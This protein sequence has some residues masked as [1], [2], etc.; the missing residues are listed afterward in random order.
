MKHL[1][2]KSLIAGL[3]ILPLIAHA[4]GTQT[5]GGDQCKNEINKQRVTIE[6]WIFDGHASELDFSKTSNW[7]YFGSDGKQSYRS[8]ML[9]VL[10]EG[11]VLITCYLDPASNSKIEGVD[12]KSITVGNPA[13][14]ST[15]INYEDKHGRSRIDCNYDLVM[16][17]NSLGDPNFKNIHHE[18]AS[19]AGLE[20][21]TSDPSDMRISNQL[22][23]FES[24]KKVKFLGPKKVE[25][26]PCKYDLYANNFILKK[27][28]DQYSESD[29]FIL[30][31]DE[32][33]DFKKTH[34][35]EGVRAGYLFQAAEGMVGKTIKGSDLDGTYAR[36][37]TSTALYFS[38]SDTEWKKAHFKVVVQ[39]MNG[40][41][42]FHGDQNLLNSQMIVLEN[43]KFK[44]C[45][46]NKLA[47]CAYY[48][49]ENSLVKLG[50]KIVHSCSQ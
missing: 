9:R 18:F 39:E 11:K 20:R 46:E 47:Q 38:A 4:Q 21:R 8:E 48:K 23:E 40:N 32:N 14:G 28:I 42:S 1:I 2:S 31:G 41:L 3:F 37:L 25:K 34:T 19:I 26:K 44:P 36:A 22:S 15:C 13:R 10:Q 6:K 27:Q 17:K 45:V 50:V 33:T 35:V 12:R 30:F 49:I 7:N 24:Y 43:L 29:I 5:G 16:N